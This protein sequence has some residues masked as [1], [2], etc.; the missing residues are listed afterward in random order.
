MVHTSGYGFRGR[1]RRRILPVQVSTQVTKGVSI[2]TMPTMPTMP[3]MPDI[4]KVKAAGV[5]VKAQ[6]MAMKDTMMSEAE[7]RRK[8]FKVLGR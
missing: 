6:G 2:P 8:R 3:K 7:K 1:K 5:A 4:E